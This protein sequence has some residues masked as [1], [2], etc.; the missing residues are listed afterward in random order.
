MKVAGRGAACA[1]AS[2]RSPR[3][4]D[5]LASLLV[6]DAE[7]FGHRLKAGADLVREGTMV[8]DKDIIIKLAQ[9]RRETFESSGEK[10]PSL[11]Y[12]EL[13]RV[14]LAAGPPPPMPPAPALNAGAVSVTVQPEQKEGI[15]GELEDGD[16]GRALEMAAVRARLPPGH[17]PAADGEAAAAAAAQ[18]NEDALRAAD[19]LAQAYPDWR[20]VDLVRTWIYARGGDEASEMA[21]VTRYRAG[22]FD[23]EDAHYGPWASALSFVLA[24]MPDLA[25]TALGE[26]AL[27]VAEHQTPAGVRRAMVN[28][29]GEI[30]RLLEER[31]KTGHAQVARRLARDVAP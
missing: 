22:F 10:W 13:L 26:G 14:I 21:A 28:S 7:T 17:E 9:T 2:M 19:R 16:G 29:Y 20:P 30:A 5:F 3:A 23:V 24:E 11:A 25:L 8:L 18:R 12:G 4:D 31:G 15:L 6:G 27:Q 1:T